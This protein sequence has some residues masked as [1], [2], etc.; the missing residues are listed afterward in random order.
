MNHI[1][2]TPILFKG[3][4]IPDNFAQFVLEAVF[5]ELFHLRLSLS[6]ALGRAV[7]TLAD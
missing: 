3:D 7:K 2:K 6:S 1:V 4:F 5:S